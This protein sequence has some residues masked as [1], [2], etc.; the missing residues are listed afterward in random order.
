ME[1]NKMNFETK[2]RNLIKSKYAKN[3]DFYKDFFD[4]TN[5]DIEK[6][7]KQ[8]LS[9][10]NFPTI[11]SAIKICDFFGCDLEYLFTEQNEFSRNVSDLALELGL[12]YDTIKAIQ[13]LSLEEKHIIDAMFNTRFFQEKLIK[14]IQEMLYYA[15]SKNK[16]YIKLDT[17]LTQKDKNFKDLEQLINE[18]DLID[19]FSN[20]LVIEMH[21]LL[22]ALYQDKTLCNEI[23]LYYSKK[24][25]TSH[26]KTLTADELPQLSPDGSLDSKREIE[27]LEDKILKRLEER[28]KIGNYWP[29][30]CEK[31]QTTSDLSRIMSEFRNNHNIT[32][33]AYLKKLQYIDEIT[34]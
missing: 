25:F 34:K 33:D 23:S 21:N 18:N 7:C 22:E 29:Y 32:E 26:K 30:K 12:D 9:G 8:W 10:N 5:V 6:K 16:T 20:R 1:L 27:Q 28:E 4:K 24:Y 19:I 31:V 11:E 13:S 3:T 14:S 17:A 15:H 2:L